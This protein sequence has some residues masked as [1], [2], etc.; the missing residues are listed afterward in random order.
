ML[1]LDLFVWLGSVLGANVCK[2]RGSRCASAGGELRR[3]L[4]KGS[5]WERIVTRAGSDQCWA[6]MC[7]KPD[8][9][10]AQTLVGSCN[11]NSPA[12]GAHSK[13]HWLGPELGAKPRGREQIILT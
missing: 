10:H 9:R 12:F 8:G 6:P 13:P 1:S 2:T 7:V 11:V 4:S 5:L 3:D